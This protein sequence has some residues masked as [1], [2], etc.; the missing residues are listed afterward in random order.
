MEVH[1][2]EQS[3]NTPFNNLRADWHIAHRSLLASVPTLALAGSLVKKELVPVSEGTLP[4]I[5]RCLFLAYAVVLIVGCSEL[6][7]LS[8]HWGRLPN[9]L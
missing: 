4:S 9:I 7:G 6:F 3:V 1:L 8:S 2:P 5:R